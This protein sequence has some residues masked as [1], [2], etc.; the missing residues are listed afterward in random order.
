[1]NFGSGFLALDATVEHPLSASAL[2]AVEM[3]FPGFVVIFF[4]GLYVYNVCQKHGMSPKRDF[5]PYP[6]L[7]IYGAFVDDGGRNLFSGQG[8]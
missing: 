8:R 2:A 1:M 3:K 6:T 7:N 5:L 4:V